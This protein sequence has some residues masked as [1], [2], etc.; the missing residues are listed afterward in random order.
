MSSTEIKSLQQKLKE[1]NENKGIASK[2]VGEAKKNDQPTDALIENVKTISTEIKLLQT[3]IKD[4]KA[5]AAEDIEKNVTKKIE[6][7]P[8]FQLS[9]NYSPAS[10]SVLKVVE[11]IDDDKWDEYVNNHP[12]S[13]IYHTSSIRNVISKSFS[14]KCYYLS[15]VDQ[16]QNIHGVLPLV[17]LKSRI[18]GHFLASV[19]FF[20]YGGILSSSEEASALLMDKAS[21]LAVT[22]GVQHIEYRHCYKNEN[23]PTR[24]DKVTMLLNLPDSKEQLWS[25]LGTKVRAQIKKSEKNSLETKIGRDELVNDFYKVFSINMRDLG[26]PVYSKQLF[27]NM[28]RL[29]SSSKLC[30]IYKNQKPVSAGFLVGWKN[31]MEIP[32]AS[33]LKSA[34]KYDANMKLYWEILK[35]TQQNGYKIFDFGRSSKNANTYKFKKQWGA[36]PYPLYWHYWLPEDQNLPEINPNNP[37]FKLLITVWKKLPILI[38]NRLGP[39]IVKFAP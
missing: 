9:K 14:H 3:K 28:L 12:N 37:K 32:W 6:L 38:A 31:T 4:L 21:K 7:P 2:A 27:I 36:K 24:S 25:K 11:D 13:T 10:F 17:E 20:N 16:D 39:N 18:F 33:T 29:I 1:L 19:P 34:N 23:L 22:T 5:T 30:V 15:A 26:T 35:H 8:Q